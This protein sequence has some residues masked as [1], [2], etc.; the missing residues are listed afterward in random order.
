VFIGRFRK[1]RVDN[2]AGN[3]KTAIQLLFYLTE[4]IEVFFSRQD[5]RPGASY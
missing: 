3:N 2:F 4:W 1:I 5:D